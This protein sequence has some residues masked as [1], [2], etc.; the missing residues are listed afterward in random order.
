MGDFQVT[1]MSWNVNGLGGSRFEEFKV[2]LSLH[3]H[4]K[5]VCLQETHSK[6]V[7]TIKNWANELSI[8]N[9]YFNHGDGRNNGTAILIHKSLPF[10]LLL[11][12]QDWQEGRFTI[13]K[14][15]LLNEL[16]TI[17]SIYA[18]V[19][20]NEKAWF[21]ER[22]LSCNLEGVKIISGDY[23][24][25][26][27]SLLDRSR[28]VSP[29][30][31]FLEFIDFTDTVDTFRFL[32]PSKISY[33][34]G[35]TSRIDLILLSSHFS[36]YLVHADIAP[37]YFSDHRPTMA[38]VTFGNSIFGKDFKKI[39][40]A[41]IA[42]DGYD[43]VFHSIWEKCLKK[44]RGEILEK[45][46]NGNF[47]GDPSQ[48]I[49]S[50]VNGFNY[51]HEVVLQ[52]LNLS[53]EWWDN[54]K[55]DILHASL[56]FQRQNFSE[57]KKLFHQLQRDF[58]RLRDGDESK[59]IVEQQLFSLLREITKEFNFQKAKDK[60]LTHERYSAA[61]FRQASKDRKNSFL[62]QL[63]GFNEEILTDRTEI[64]DHLLLQ[65]FYLYQGEEMN[66]ENLKFFMKYVPKLRV[67]E[68]TSP[69]T[70]AEA[71][72]VFKE[73]ASGTCPGP[74]GIPIEFYK[75]YFNFFGHFY[76][77]MINNCIRD[78]V[79]PNSWKYSILK[80]IPKVPDE[81]PSFDTLRPLTLGNVDCKHEAGMLCK[82]MVIVAQ[83]VIHKLQTGGIPNR[84]IQDSTFLIH[85]L[86]NLFKE[87]DWG[88]YIGALDNVKA[89]DKLIRDFM[90]LIL[91]EMG[92]DPWT[93]QAIQNLYKE[94][95]ACLII[96]G[97]LSEPFPVDSGVKQGC[98]LSSLLFTI[99][100]EPL[101]R[102]ILEDPAFHGFG[103]RLPGNK[104]VRLI[105]HLDDMTL[106]ANNS[107]TF[108][109][110]FKK[111]MLY[112]SLSGASINYKKS[113]IIRLDRKSRVLSLDGK[114]ICNIPVLKDGECRK[115]L[116]I[117]YNHD[118]DCYVEAN[119]DSVYTKCTNALKMW[120]LCFSSNGTTSLMGRSLV[121][122]VM[123]HSKVFYLMQCMQ[124]H[125]PIILKLDSDVQTFL[126]SGK[127]H[128]P[129]IQLQILEAPAKLG[130][131]GLKPLDLVAISLRFCHIKN[132]FNRNNESW[133]QEK[134]PAE[135]IM[136][137]FLDLSVRT[138]VGNIERLAPVLN[139][140]YHKPGSVKFIKHLPNIF[141]VLYWDI[142]RAISIIG[143]ADSIENYSRE[144]FLEDLMVRRSIT[145]RQQTV[146]MPY[147]NLFTLPLYVEE[148]L[149][150][151]ISLKLLEPKV[152][153]FSY[154]LAHD[155]LPTKYEI[156]RRTRHFVGNEHD[157]WCQFCKLVL[158]DN[159]DC[160]TKH[161]FME[162]SVA[163][164][165]WGHINSALVSSGE[166]PY[167]INERFVFLRL[168]LN[169]YDSYFI[170]EC[171]WAIWR[172]NNHNNYDITPEESHKLWHSKSA[173][174]IFK[175]RI[176]FISSLD[177]AN[178]QEKSY[179]KKWSSIINKTTHVFDNG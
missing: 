91:K 83:D 175:K 147:I 72:T 124:F 42:S 22:V 135:A 134:S 149:W 96:N 102:S 156:W 94:T 2:A 8:Y 126:W 179:K 19:Q 153:A 27:N 166:K 7:N 128:I 161:I 145:L 164:K 114:K 11:E 123:V 73:T 98:P 142:E 10:K 146:G 82:R 52:N 21:F 101:A 103:F 174:E 81:I 29:V 66:K 157:P 6:N 44:F 36:N 88:G 12:I 97:F 113:F 130:G 49:D 140:R 51:T 47:V 100:M 61:F 5:I 159:V 71:N 43:A 40:P 170:T 160:T 87:N 39:R 85:L 125:S 45:L 15:T 152:R 104:E 167:K 67:K 3:N 89:F 46:N 173:L 34:Y 176:T 111:I 9:C 119:W 26:P 141:D 109:A 4:P 138:L 18:P 116:G 151:N 1:S 178:L 172:V 69:F 136:C 108:R 16:V 63:K 112:N 24:A 155:C 139:S 41:T 74:D 127:R 129:K 65:Y 168:G 133:F 163:K 90:F 79:V 28:H 23:N 57:K 165:F 38:S 110:F 99:A 30:K 14:G 117:L 80:V 106:F 120:T 86:I 132:Y 48:V 70:F 55:K 62:T 64:Q 78:K 25:V 33:S 56:N 37:K 93:I 53:P 13:L 115:I 107:H 77:Q 75:K 32:H 177:R 20:D 121:I 92:F 31:S 148:Y 59:K 95:F 105:Q 144:S 50:S 35:E 131:I 68:K 137:Y 54:F 17:C 60:R 169:Q 58:Y 150:K 84:K 118:V 171:L 143:S 158:L 162:C 154:K 76:V 122:H